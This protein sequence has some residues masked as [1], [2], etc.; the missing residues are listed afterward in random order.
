MNANTNLVA[1]AEK[2]L[3]TVVN[4]DFERLIALVGSDGAVEDPRFGRI[5]GEQSL[6][7]FMANI[8]KWLEEF[9]PRVQHVRTTKTDKRVCSEDILHVDLGEEQW[10]LGVGT[11][12]GY[13]KVSGAAEVHVYYTNWPFNN[14]SHSH[15]PALFDEPE[16]GAKH[17]DV[18]LRYY[19]SLVTGDLEKLA[20]CF[21]ADI[22][23]REPSGPPYVHWGTNAVIEYFK[24]LFHNGAPML[25]EDTVTD[26]GRCAIMEFTVIGWNG[27][28]WGDPSQYH[29]GLACYERSKEGLMRAIRIY[30]DVD[31][32]PES[33]VTAG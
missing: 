22:Y 27:K 5:T 8:Q 18:I 30:D 1:I 19:Q 16:P 13:H 4:S 32:T 14:H 24:G 6:K 23:F 25:R 29:A 7:Q 11:V 20:T 12:V 33:E 28:E 3:N 2:Y 17:T 10:E 21:E 26:D 9:S 31:F 15:R